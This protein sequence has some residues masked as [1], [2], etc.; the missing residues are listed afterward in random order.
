MHSD[1]GGRYEMPSGKEIIGTAI[2]I[3]VVLIGLFWF[4][5]TGDER[6]HYRV[7][8]LHVDSRTVE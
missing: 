8:N 6:A 4:G 5:M 3:V 2:F 1:F 7:K